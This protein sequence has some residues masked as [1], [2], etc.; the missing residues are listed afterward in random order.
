MVW[1]TN[2]PSPA[3]TAWYES[4]ARH[5]LS[6]DL[7]F[8]KIDCMW[9]GPGLE[10]NFD[11]DVLAFA[12]AFSSLSPNITVSWS[13]GGGMTIQNGT[14]IS[15][16]KGKYGVAYRVT[17]DFHDT[18]GWPRLIR[19]ADTAALFA[20]LIG[21]GGTFPD[22]DMLP[23]GRQAPDSHLCQYSHDEQRF[24]LTLWAI[25]R[26]PL[27]LGAQL[28]LDANDTWTLPLITNRAVLA[29][30]SGSCGNAPVPVLNA[31]PVNLTAW[32]AVA[33]G[34]GLTSVY[35]LFNMRD[36]GP[37]EVSVAVEAAGGSSPLCVQ[38][39][40]TGQEEGVLKGATLTR[41]VNAHAGGL[42][43]VGPC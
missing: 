21:A 43:A 9:A 32:S 38:D 42:W 31:Q 12:Q 23:L 34:D 18:N 26:S 37:V 5:Y 16:F 6:Q 2:A 8:I 35:A 15:S 20:P 40:W 7:D 29:V 30:N 33:E 17:P 36:S 27:I 14:W 10:H 4:L 3:A 22:L 19:Q 13:P 41:P 24:I 11:E 28:P 39:L 25:A 1:G